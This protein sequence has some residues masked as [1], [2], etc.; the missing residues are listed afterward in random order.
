M[1]KIIVTLYVLELSDG[2]YYVGQSNEPDFRYQDHLLANGSKWTR[3]YPAISRPVCKELEFESLLE[4]KLH[5]NWL[6]LHWM[7]MKGWENVRGGDFL[8]IEDYRLKELIDHIFDAKLNRIRYFVPKCPYLF[9]VSQDWIIY[10][11][12]LENGCFYIG[13]T[14][15]LGKALGK[16]FLG[17]GIDFTRINKPLR[18]LDYFTVPPPNNYLEV[19]RK[20]LLEHVGYYGKDKVLGGNF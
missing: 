7:G 5:E 3:M 18:V 14:K 8:V 11:L 6:T 17:K 10:V 15:R 12:E 1:D 4:A 16:H 13:S 20:M 19:K 2:K 9:G